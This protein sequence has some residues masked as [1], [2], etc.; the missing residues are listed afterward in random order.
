ME[1]GE[2]VNMDSEG[3]LKKPEGPQI[4]LGNI[5]KI[6][7][8]FD[9]EIYRRLKYILLCCMKFPNN[10]SSLIK[11]LPRKCLSYKYSISDADKPNIASY[12][13]NFSIFLNSSVLQRQINHPRNP[14]HHSLNLEDLLY[15]QWSWLAKELCLHPE[16]LRRQLP[17]QLERTNYDLQHLWWVR[18]FELLDVQL[19]VDEVVWSQSLQSRLDLRH[20]ASGW[21]V[22]A[23]WTRLGA[24]VQP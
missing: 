11:Y 10:S 19:M 3:N 24:M 1:T 4:E 15:L 6:I 14:I 16:I 12:Q 5:W 21:A 18:V 22:P 2:R 23:Q 17:R 13:P 9:I 8:W 20:A 7:L